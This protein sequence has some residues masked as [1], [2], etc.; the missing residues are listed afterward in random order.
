MA[1]LPGF[2]ERFDVTA[3][4]L[5][6]AALERLTD[7]DFGRLKKH[8]HFAAIGAPAAPRSPATAPSG[9]KLRAKPLAELADIVL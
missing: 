4:Q 9:P 6:V 3:T 5:T 8:D 2:K 1:N 7:L